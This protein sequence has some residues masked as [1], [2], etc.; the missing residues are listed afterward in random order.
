M[1]VLARNKSLDSGLARLVQE[2]EASREE[3]PDPLAAGLPRA[4]T[5]GERQDDACAMALS[6]RG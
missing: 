4:L 3:A 6:L 5:A 2:V 1:S